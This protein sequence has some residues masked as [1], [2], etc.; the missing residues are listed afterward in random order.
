MGFEVA[1]PRT[2]TMTDGNAWG[3]S[4]APVVIIE[5]SDFQ[6]S[7]CRNF[8]LETEEKFEEKYIA[9]GQVRLVYRSFGDALGPDSATAAQA[10]YCA[11]DQEMFWEMHDV[12]FYSQVPNS[13]ENLSYMAYMLGLDTNTF[14]QCLE[15]EK[16]LARTME[17]KANAI[18]AGVTGTPSFV[19]NGQLAIIGNAPF[20]DFEEYIDDLLE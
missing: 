11:G 8:F 5:Y 1:E 17:D 13:F 19:I 10:A 16:Y 9:T 18:A 15:S 20:G 4:N 2:R 7:H 6:C 3:D 14:D 12:I